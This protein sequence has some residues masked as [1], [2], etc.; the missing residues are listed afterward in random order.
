MAKPCIEK[1]TPRNNA[2]D[3]HV[4]ARIQLRRSVLGMPQADLAKLIFAKPSRIAAMERGHA[5]IS[6]REL[7]ALSRALNIAPSW[8]FEELSMTVTPEQDFGEPPASNCG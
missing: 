7:F 5:K 4:G 2:V 3:L 6:V 8:F 1:T